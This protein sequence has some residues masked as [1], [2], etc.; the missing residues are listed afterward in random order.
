[1]E[2]EFR[3]NK[4]FNVYGLTENGFRQVIS[5]LDGKVFAWSEDLYDTEK[6]KLLIEGLGSWGRNFTS[7]EMLTQFLAKQ[8]PTINY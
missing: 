2:S 1:M 8:H 4:N 3:Y 5:F 6:V 7:K